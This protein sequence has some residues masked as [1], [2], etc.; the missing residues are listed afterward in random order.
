MMTSL[1]YGTWMLPAASA[2]AALLNSSKA[3]FPFPQSSRNYR[4]LARNAPPARGI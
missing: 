4:N 3:R 2:I 1:I